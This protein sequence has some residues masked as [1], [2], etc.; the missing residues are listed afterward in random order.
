M[1][2]AIK[3]PNNLDEK[4]MSF[5]FLHQF[6]KLME[7]KLEKEESDDRLNIHLISNK[8]SIDALNLLPF[9]A[10]YHEIEDDELK[11]IF[12][13]HRACTKL[14]IENV[15]VFISTT[16]SFVDASIGKNLKAKMA[17]GFSNSK[18]NLFLNKKIQ[19]NKE[20]HL[21]SRIYKLIDIFEFENIPKMGH[22]CSR[23]L[24][25]TISTWSEEPYT[26]IDLSLKDNLVHPEWIEF[27]EL[28]ENK[29]FIFMCSEAD[30]YLQNGILNDFLKTLP[31]KNAYDVFEFSNHIDFA[32][33]AS[34]A[35]TFVSENSSLINFASYCGT[36]SFFIDRLNRSLNLDCRFFY[37][38]VVKFSL[39]DMAATDGL[40]FRYE[41]IFD[42]VYAYINERTKDKNE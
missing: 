28:F 27:I 3:V 26:V 30:P 22:V 1:N 19:S 8:S 23:D 37:G 20:E 12:T 31:V 38:E 32:K 40:D 10:Y 4:V 18:N 6:V 34:F 39:A 13:V 42:K 35:I 2:I 7:E 15:D 17:I 5:P 21:A 9:K 25:P 41:K 33:L 36:H 11:T 16:D 24:E 14:T 29:K